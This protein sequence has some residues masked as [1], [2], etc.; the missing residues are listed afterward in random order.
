L[1]E[2]ILHDVKESAGRFGVAIFR[3]DVKDLAFPGNLQ[4]IMNRVLAAERM[5]QVQLVEARSKSE[6]QK[7]EAQ[8]K[9]ETQR[10]ESE[11]RL[12]AERLSAEAE[13][14]IQQIKTEAE[15]KEL[16]ERERTA[17]AYTTHPAL[18]RILELETLRQLGAN[19]NARIYIG[20]DK[21]AL[22]DGAPKEP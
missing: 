11:A 20:F 22:P 8:T 19:A 5:S 15:V 18:L 2:D 3:A 17:R 21:H 12:A 1:S 6:V 14:Q 10:L 16:Q 9:A 4:E 13:A 7:I